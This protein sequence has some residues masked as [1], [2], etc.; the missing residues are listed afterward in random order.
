MRSDVRTAARTRSGWYEQ[1]AE[2]KIK[3][4]RLKVKERWFAQGNDNIRDMGSGRWEAL[5]QQSPWDTSV[6]EARRK[7]PGRRKLN[8]SQRKKMES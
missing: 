3:E 1:E 2:S 7:N 6:E 5:F 4:V 8:F